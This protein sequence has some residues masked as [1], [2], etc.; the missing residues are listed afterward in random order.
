MDFASRLRP[1]LLSAM[2]LLLTPG[3][4]PAAAASGVSWSPDV[5]VG[6]VHRFTCERALAATSTSGV[7]V[8]HAVYLTVNAPTYGDEK[9]FARR[10]TDGGATWLAGTT[11]T[12][13]P[14]VWKEC[15]TIAGSGA[16]LVAAWRQGT[17]TATAIRY[18]VSTDGGV[19]WRPEL[20][21][22]TTRT[23]GKPSVAVTGST[24]AI[25]WT[26]SSG[27]DR[28]SRIALSRN[29][30]STW[31]LRT[32]DARP[33]DPDTFSP[34]T[35]QVSASGSR[36]FVA[37][38]RVGGTRLVG[39]SSIDGGITWPAPT[40]LATAFTPAYQGYE[41]V[42]NRTQFSLAARPDR[43]ALAWTGGWPATAG[44][45]ELFVRVFAN[46]VWGSPSTIT[47]V[48]G[49]GQFPY[50]YFF[51]PAATLLASTRVGVAAVVCED[52]RSADPI[53]GCGEPYGG[54]FHALWVESTGNGSSW[55]AP[56]EVD[57]GAG[58][59]TINAASAIWM[60]TGLRG[61]LVS[62]ANGEPEWDY[63]ITFSR[64]SGSP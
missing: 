51:S 15:P 55:T 42:P 2:A 13:N 44:H 60:S 1:A 37:W 30:G 8:L 41:A 58:Y 59:T 36:I 25:A 27:T 52:L 9:I 39:R 20:R 47:A 46:G 26:D 32:L 62:R 21:L 29:R 24:V 53:Y 38:L 64:G 10:S 31:T 57:P 3:A 12:A 48:A 49:A 34:P 63:R 18:R 6:P 16:F 7:A 14:T 19:T 22:P 23:P 33:T 17:R 54:N 35:T 45:P 56:A 4:L 5:Q 40:V 61:V 11:L 28:W 50:G 43:M